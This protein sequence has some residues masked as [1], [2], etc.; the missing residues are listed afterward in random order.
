MRLE[1]APGGALG[2]ECVGRRSIGAAI[3]L[4][5]AVFFTATIALIDA[6]AAGMDDTAYFRVSDGKPQDDF[7]IAL[8]DPTKIASA[9]ALINKANPQTRF[10]AGTIIPH[11]AG[12]NAPWHFFLEPES[13]V[14]IEQS[15]E[16]CSATTSYVEAHLAEVGGAFLPRAWWC[17][18]RSR[19][20]AEIHSGR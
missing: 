7:V 12:Y 2:V 13:I 14:F 5:A 17:P 20:T 6:H 19:V 4:F 10:L 15:I 18:W 1:L 3:S 8:T 11:P 9:R 16:V